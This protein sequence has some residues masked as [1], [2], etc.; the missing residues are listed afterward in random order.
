MWNEPD[1]LSAN[2]IGLKITKNLS[3]SAEQ[4]IDKYQT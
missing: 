1:G 4:I 2:K 3:Q